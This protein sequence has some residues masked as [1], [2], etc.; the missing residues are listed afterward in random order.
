LLS[1]SLSFFFI[2]S[3]IFLFVLGGTA[4]IVTANNPITTER[5]ALEVGI[6]AAKTENALAIVA[7]PA[8]RALWNGGTALSAL[9]LLVWSDLGKWH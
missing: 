6:V 3:F 8:V 4:S 2:F 5:N 7:S 1:F 9:A